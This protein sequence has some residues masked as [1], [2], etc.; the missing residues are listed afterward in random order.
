MGGGGGGGVLAT[1]ETDLVNIASL[2]WCYKLSS[3][4]DDLGLTAK[5]LVEQILGQKSSQRHDSVLV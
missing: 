5:Q 1:T 3:Q 2:L 4:K